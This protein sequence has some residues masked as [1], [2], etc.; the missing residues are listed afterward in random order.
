M[1]S[2][3][4]VYWSTTVIWVRPYNFFI[5]QYWILQNQNLQAVLIRR[6]FMLQNYLIWLTIIKLWIFFFSFAKVSSNENGCPSSSTIHESFIWLKFL[7]R[8]KQNDKYGTS[9]CH[10]YIVVHTVWE[11]SSSIKS[12]ISHKHTKWAVKCIKANL[13]KTRVKLGL[14]TLST[15]AIMSG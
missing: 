7:L 3:H 10:L 11:V 15:P 2:Q 12:E 4:H 1:T 5:F 14:D 9:K 13:I 8:K 6:S